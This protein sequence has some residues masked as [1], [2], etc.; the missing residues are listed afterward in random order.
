MVFVGSDR[1]EL[2]NLYDGFK[3]LSVRNSVFYSVYIYIYINIYIDLDIDIYIY[4][5]ILYI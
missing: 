3:L 5:S 2:L 1:Y 4:I